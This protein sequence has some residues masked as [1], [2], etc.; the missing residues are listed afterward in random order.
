MAWLATGEADNPPALP[1]INRLT[2]MESEQNQYYSY[3]ILVV[4]V[5]LVYLTPY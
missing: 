4:V 3:L 5:F 1:Y 2:S